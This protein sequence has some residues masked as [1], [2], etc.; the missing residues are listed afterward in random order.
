MTVLHL[1]ETEIPIMKKQTSSPQ[2]EKHQLTRENTEIRAQVEGFIRKYIDERIGELDFESLKNESLFLGKIYEGLSL[3]FEKMQERLFQMN[4]TI[5][6]DRNANDLNAWLLTGQG[7]LMTFSSFVNRT[8]E[9]IFQEQ[10]NVSQNLKNISAQ[11]SERLSP[12][13]KNSIAF[14]AYMSQN[15]PT[16]SV[17]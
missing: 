12:P 7:N 17:Q 3:G 6:E 1:N 2:R 5:N 16:I 8:T 11:L 13:T 10:N 15:T 9:H 14:Y 4:K